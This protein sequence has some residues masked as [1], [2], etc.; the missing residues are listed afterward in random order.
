M[1]EKMSGMNGSPFNPKRYGWSRNVR[2][3]LMSIIVGIVAGFG[4]IGFE[5][6]LTFI[7]YHAL[8]LTTGYVEPVVGAGL[9]KVTAVASTHSWL[10]L[11]IPALGAL[12][13]R[14]SSI[15]SLRGGGRG[16]RRH[17]RILP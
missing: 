16:H 5:A 8:E 13:S 2:W 15:S 3:P 1:P 4:T 6:L 14:C 7:K 17:D 11:L 12:V 9:E 10:F